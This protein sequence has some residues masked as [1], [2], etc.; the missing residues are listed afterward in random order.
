MQAI[1]REQLDS[2]SMQAD[3]LRPAEKLGLM[4]RKR[5]DAIFLS[6]HRVNSDLDIARTGRE[7]RDTAV[8]AALVSATHLLVQRASLEL[9]IAPEEFEILEPRTLMGRPLIQFADFLVNGA[10]FARRLVDGQPP[11]VIE[12]TRSM[13]HS[14]LSDP[15]VNSFFD[16]AH[17]RDCAHSCYACLQRYGNRSYHGLLDWRLGLAMLRTFVSPDSVIG[18]DGNWAAIPELSDWPTQARAAAK[19]IA[20]LHP[21]RYHVLPED[22]GQM[23]VIASTQD[24]IRWILVHPF[25]RHD[26]VARSLQPWSGQTLLIDTFQAMRRPQRALRNAIFLDSHS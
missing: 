25:W 11:L 22:S 23:P 14:P 7:P 26:A 19:G 10:G 12:L 18:L 24:R 2:G 6:P 15:L 3:P 4:A 13:V 9:D 17:Q 1:E 20:E 8:R 16:P 5:T 21:D